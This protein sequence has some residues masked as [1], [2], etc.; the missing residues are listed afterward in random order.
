MGSRA[1][2]AQGI[3]LLSGLALIIDTEHFPQG[4]E[5][6][7]DFSAMNDYAFLPTD[8]LIGLSRFPSHYQADFASMQGDQYSF[9]SAMGPAC[10]DGPVLTMG[11]SI[12]V[13]E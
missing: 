1:S 6:A 3:V 4:A 9:R 7:I 8:G 13:Q 5:I 12:C 10:F 11:E 2:V